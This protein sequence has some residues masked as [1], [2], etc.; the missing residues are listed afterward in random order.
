VY[1]EKQPDSVTEMHFHWPVFAADIT[2][3]RSVP[4]AEVDYRIP[5]PT[6]IK[7]NLQTTIDTLL[8]HSEL[9]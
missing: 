6:S 3:Q 5:P 4:L 7:A 2:I 8:V 9:L 1:L